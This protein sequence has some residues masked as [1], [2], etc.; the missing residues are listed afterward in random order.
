MNDET[1]GDLY[2]GYLSKL[3]PVRPRSSSLDNSLLVF[4][5]KHSGEYSNSR[6]YNI[7]R[8]Q[9]SLVLADTE[10]EILQNLEKFYFSEAIGNSKVG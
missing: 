8:K 9:G 7:L 5:R 2:I 10:E 3:K 4:F 1:N 6:M